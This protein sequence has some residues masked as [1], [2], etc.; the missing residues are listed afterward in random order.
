MSTKDVETI[1]E[2]VAA[3][4]RGDVD[5][6]VATLAP[7]VELVPLRAVLD[8]SIYRGHEGLR[9][10]LDD[11]SEDW[12]EFELALQGVSELRPGCVL[13]R[14]KIRLRGRSSG[15]SVDSPGAWLCDMRAAKVARIR[16]FADS[17]AAVAAAEES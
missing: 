14:A 11:M 13:V 17:E 2:G 5:A 6:L 3:L 16:F 7:D 9:R 1:Q 4:N 10:W 12:S 15:V 8:G